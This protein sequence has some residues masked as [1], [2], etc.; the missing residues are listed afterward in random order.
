MPA[1]A[2][3]RDTSWSLSRE[4]NRLVELLTDK[5]VPEN[6]RNDRGTVKVYLESVLLSG[7]L[8][9]VYLYDK[10]VAGDLHTFICYL[11]TESIEIHVSPTGKISTTRT[12]TGS[13]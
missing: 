13:R 5:I 11:G 3:V 2:E 12:P 1:L 9:R 10:P 8:P 7:F 4:G 6:K